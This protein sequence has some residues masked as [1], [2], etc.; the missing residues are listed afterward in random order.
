MEKW[1]TFN[2]NILSTPPKP[3][4]NYLFLTFPAGRRIFQLL[5][6]FFLANIQHN[7][8]LNSAPSKNILSIYFRITIYIYICL[9]LS[10]C[11][12]RSTFP[13]YLSCLSVCLSVRPSVRLSIPP[14]WLR[15]CKLHQ[16]SKCGPNVAFLTF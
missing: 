12:S 13:V 6:S 10:L 2:I 14:H 7:S 15:T 8:N 1:A 3:Y 9:S 16:T 4:S 5:F 11:P